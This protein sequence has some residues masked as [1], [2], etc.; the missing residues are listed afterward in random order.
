MTQ[1][2]FFVRNAAIIRLAPAID[3]HRIRGRM[4]ASRRLLG[5]FL[6]GYPVVCLACLP[7]ALPVWNQLLRD[8]IGRALSAELLHLVQY[9]PL[10]AA[11]RLYHRTARLRRAPLDRSGIR[12]TG[13]R[14]RWLVATALGLVGLADEGIQAL[15]PGRY[16]QWS[17]V[18][19]NWIGLAMGFAL[20]A[21]GQGARRSP[22]PPAE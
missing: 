22:A 15:L 14:Q 3:E 11:A 9:A 19:L 2:G 5:G 10:G 21:T 18:R 7:L 8:G 6:V 1:G 16:F 17:D 12:P 13:R 20:A 4:T